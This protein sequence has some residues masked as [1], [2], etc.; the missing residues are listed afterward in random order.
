MLD[1]GG[2]TEQVILKRLKPKHLVQDDVKVLDQD[3]RYCW[4][5]SPSGIL[6]MSIKA[7]GSG[8]QPAPVCA[9]TAT[10]F[11]CCIDWLKSQLL[12]MADCF[13]LQ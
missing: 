1:I 4:V 3:S 9:L 10:D 8:F 6:V 13:A 7:D 2:R 11:T 5:P 12:C